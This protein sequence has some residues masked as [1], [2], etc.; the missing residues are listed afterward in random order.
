[1]FKRF[2]LEGRVMCLCVFVYAHNSPGCPCKKQRAIM[3]SPVK[4]KK[5]EA[6]LVNSKKFWKNIYILNIS[7]QESIKIDEETV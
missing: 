6:K 1:M 7:L 3:N 5:R 4:T 2:S